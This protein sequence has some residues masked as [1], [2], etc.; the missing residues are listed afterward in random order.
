MKLV[1]K[2]VVVAAL[3]CSAMF[4]V[5]CGG[6]EVE[7]KVTVKDALGNACGKET[8]VEFYKG[9]EKAGVQICGEDGTAKKVLPKGTYKLRITSTDKDVSYSYE[10]TKVTAGKNNVVVLVSNE[11]SGEKQELYVNG[12]EKAAFYVDAGC[13]TVELAKGERNYY[14]FAPNQAGTYE[15]SVKCDS[16][17]EIGYYGTPHFVQENSAAEVKDGKFKISISESMIG[18]GNTGTTVVVIGVDSAKK[19]DAVLCVNRIGDAEWKVEDAE[20]KIYE[21][22]VE[23]SKY[24]LPAGKTLVDFD[25]FSTT[26]YK[27]IFN[28]KDGFY[29]LNDENGP[30]VVVYLAKDPNHSY[31]PC[32]KTILERSGISKYVYDEDGTFVE[33]VSYSECL[34]EYIEY[35]DDN[36]GVY[37]LTEDLKTIIQVRGNYVGWWDST[38]P[39]FVFK[40]NA[41]TPVP[42][43]NQE[44]AWLFLCAYVQ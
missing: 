25:I 18:T 31:L 22:T 39:G 30:L 20:W 17:T 9:K 4:L 13:T 29:H 6:G 27:L 24:T 11:V 1:K 40:D 15:F 16:K 33:K 2:L 21:K 37:P 12:K 19:T 43:L 14:L 5:A 35:A 44:T 7:Y 3:M 38:S 26:D 23:L 41:G 34:L 32:F 8:M 36:V 10:E 28:T 42:G